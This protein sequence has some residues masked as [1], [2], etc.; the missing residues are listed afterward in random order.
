[1]RGRF[2]LRHPW[3]RQTFEGRSVLSHVTNTY[4]DQQIKKEHAEIIRNLAKAFN[5]RVHSLGLAGAQRDQE[6]VA[7]WLG[8]SSAYKVANMTTLSEEVARI[9][10]VEIVPRGYQAIMD[11]LLP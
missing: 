9:G 4:H 7:F 5:E 11:L 1:M 8:A 2:E 10:V 6:A 3:E